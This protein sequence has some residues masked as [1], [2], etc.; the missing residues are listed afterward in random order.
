M[1]GQPPSRRHHGWYLCRKRISVRMPFFLWNQ[2][3]EHKKVLLEGDLSA[4]RMTG[5]CRLREWV[6]KKGE[7]ERIED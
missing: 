6:L 2:D 7:K 4:E 1:A 5:K 3:E